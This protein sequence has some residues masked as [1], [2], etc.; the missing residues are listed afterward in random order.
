[1]ICA[2]I[3]SNYNYY[4]ILLNTSFYTITRCAENER[5]DIFLLLDG[6]A[7]D[8]KHVLGK[9]SVRWEYSMDGC[10]SIPGHHIQLHTLIHTFKQ[11]SIAKSPTGLFFKARREKNNN[12]SSHTGE[13]HQRNSILSPGLDQAS[14]SCE[15]IMRLNRQTKACFLYLRKS[16]WEMVGKKLYLSLITKA[17]KNTFFPPLS[18]KCLKYNLKESPCFN[19]FVRTS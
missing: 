17:T 8:P 9:L 12:W 6:F 16:Y 13:T 2:F 19:F 10:Q 15:T 18:I 3:K 7:L 11:F 4:F 1:M 14:R 5:R